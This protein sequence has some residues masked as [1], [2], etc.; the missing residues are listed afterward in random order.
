MITK[1][2]LAGIIIVIC[3]ATKTVIPLVIVNAQ[4]PAKEFSLDKICSHSE[5]HPAENM[6]SKNAANNL[7][8]YKNA[9]LGFRIQYPA[10]WKLTQDD[11]ILGNR[12]LSQSSSNLNFVSS[13]A[14][15]EYGLVG[16]TVSDFI[17]SRPINTFVDLYSKDFADIIKSKEIITFA[18]LPAAKFI[19]KEGNH[20]RLLITT[21][22]NNRKYDITYPI[23]SWFSNST[24][25]SMLNSFQVMNTETNS[26]NQNDL[27]NELG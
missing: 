12:G 18:G 25:Q 21:F 17:L 6:G 24:I 11:C 26:T 13:S 15:K 4:V 5:T 2:L 3:I 16:I 14:S 27:V 22:A 7:A 9:S 8:I 20:D 1:F 19:L 23:V 10:D